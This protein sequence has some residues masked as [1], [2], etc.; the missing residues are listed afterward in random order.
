MLIQWKVTNM[1]T[2]E[3]TGLCYKVLYQYRRFLCVSKVNEGSPVALGDLLVD[4]GLEL[5]QLSPLYVTGLLPH[6]PERSK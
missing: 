5:F 3:S 2:V 6:Q 1:I 4:L